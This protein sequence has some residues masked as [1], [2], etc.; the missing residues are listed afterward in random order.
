MR[1]PHWSTGIASAWTL[2]RAA[3]VEEGWT[4]AEP[5]RHDPG[6]HRGPGRLRVPCELAGAARRAAG[7]IPAHGSG[8]STTTAAWPHKSDPVLVA[9]LIGSFVSIGVLA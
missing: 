5:V 6:V 2:P 9:D 7:A 8:S 1:T 3:R 4:Y